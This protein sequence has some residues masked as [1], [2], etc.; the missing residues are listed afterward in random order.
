MPA[1]RSLQLT[2]IALTP[3]LST[4][5]VEFLEP[6]RL[7]DLCSGDL[8]SPAG[9]AAERAAARGRPQCGADRPMHSAGAYF[10]CAVA[11]AIA[12][13]RHF[14]LHEA[15]ATAPSRDRRCHR[16]PRTAAR[17]GAVAP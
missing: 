11:G 5:E 6:R 15:R 4:L 7:D 16:T 14:C 10:P 3:P 1:R 2:C 12:S 13:R 17:M 9:F 8:P